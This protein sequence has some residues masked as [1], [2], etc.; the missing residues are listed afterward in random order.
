MR[1]ISKQKPKTPSKISEP[2]LIN[3]ANKADEET[4]IRIKT[5]IQKFVENPNENFGS[6]MDKIFEDV[7]CKIM[8]DGDI[9]NQI[10][11][12]AEVE[13]LHEKFSVLNHLLGACINR[14]KIETETEDPDEQINCEKLQQL[15][16]YKNCLIFLKERCVQLA[17]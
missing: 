4:K 15:D 14:G 9:L 13:G 8:E 5:K 1:E 16:M 6:L 12:V 11:Q 17:E 10:S 3:V 7:A 2:C